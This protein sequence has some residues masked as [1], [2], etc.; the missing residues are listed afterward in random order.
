MRGVGSTVIMHP[1]QIQTRGKLRRS[2]GHDWAQPATDAVSN[3]SIPNSLADRIPNIGSA[4]GVSGKW[5]VANP[6]PCAAAAPSI[7]RKFSE[8]RTGPKRRNQADSFARPRRRRFVSTRRPAFVDIRWR[9]P[10]F[11]ERRRAFGWYVLFTIRPD[12]SRHSPLASSPA[13]FTST[14][15]TFSSLCVTSDAVWATGWVDQ[16]GEDCGKREASPLDSDLY[17]RPCWQQQQHHPRE[18]RSA[19]ARAAIRGDR[20]PKLHRPLLTQYVRNRGRLGSGNSGAARGTDDH[21]RPR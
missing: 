4:F 3:H 1:D 19:L 10:C 17:A 12:R 14:S 16:S 21:S 18:V 20:F 2:V 15:G 13:R 5:R 11:L 6:A 8:R 9:K 7:R